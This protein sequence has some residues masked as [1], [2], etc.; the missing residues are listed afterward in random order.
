MLISYKVWCY[1]NL[2]KTLLIFF[3]FF[4]KTEEGKQTRD[5]FKDLPSNISGGD[6]SWSS[7]PRHTISCKSR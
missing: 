2:Q 3:F 7:V 5:E 6:L 1:A 4:L